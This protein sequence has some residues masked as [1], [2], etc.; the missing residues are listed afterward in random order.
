MAASGSGGDQEAS[1]G[2]VD[3]AGVRCSPGPERN[4]WPQAR[5]QA[6][7]SRHQEADQPQAHTADKLHLSVS[8]GQGS[9]IADLASISFGGALRLHPYFSPS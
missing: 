5:A 3:Q 8:Q 9:Y 6:G 2:A 4:P 1:G 7:G